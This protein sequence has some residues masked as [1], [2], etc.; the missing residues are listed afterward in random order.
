M[1]YL[2]S[3]SIDTPLGRMVVQGS[4]THI[5]SLKF[6]NTVENLMSDKKPDWLE[7]CDLQ[8][9]QYFSAQRQIFDL[10]ID[11]QGTAF[12]QRV[13]QALLDVRFGDFASYQQLA[14]AIGNA[15]AVR[16]VA[17]A[18]ANNPICLIIPCHR[19][20]GSDLALRGYAGGVVRKAKLLALEGVIISCDNM[21]LVN[22]KTKLVVK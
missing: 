20:I 11:P 10:P 2:Y 18:N 14:D 4:E 6:D 3:R 15:Q 8:I 21:N 9:A 16:A 7:A 5:Q 22:E 1:N 13:W 17:S 12:Q 19:I